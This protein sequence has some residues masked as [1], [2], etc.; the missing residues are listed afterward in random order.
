MGRHAWRSGVAVGRWRTMRRT[1]A[2]TWAPSLSSRSRSQVT[3]VRAQA[4]PAARSR[5]SYISTEAAAVKKTR[6]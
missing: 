1:E 4:V 2:T 5:S 6:S 3:G